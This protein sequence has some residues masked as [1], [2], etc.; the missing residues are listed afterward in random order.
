MRDLAA[1]RAVSA[2]HALGSAPP[3]ARR[4][5]ALHGTTVPLLGQLGPCLSLRE[6]RVVLLHNLL[7]YGPALAAF[8]GSHPGAGVW[9]AQQHLG[10]ILWLCG[11]LTAVSS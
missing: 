7:P 8:P 5:G 3:P 6:V 1:R 10:E 4:A 9:G 11:P 2:E